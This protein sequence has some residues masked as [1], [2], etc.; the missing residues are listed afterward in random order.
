M[1]FSS[2]VRV[3]D[4][5]LWWYSLWISESLPIQPVPHHCRYRA[6]QHLKLRAGAL[7]ELA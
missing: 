1:I 6:L 7:G 5:L 4:V 3:S 2:K